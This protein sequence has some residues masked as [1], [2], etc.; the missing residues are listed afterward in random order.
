[1]YSLKSTA[2][3]KSDLDS[4]I[5]KSTAGVLIH[6]LRNDWIDNLYLLIGKAYFLRNDLDSA[7]LT[8]QFV[9]YTFS[10][11]EKDGYDKVIGSNQEEGNA[12]SISTKENRNLI[13]KML[14]RPPSRNESLI[15]QVKTYLAKNELPEAGGLIETLRHDP[16]F[17]SRLS[18]DLEELQ[19]LFFY[20]QEN[21]DS[22]AVHLEQALGNAE[23]NQE[24]ARWEYLIAQLYERA[25]H[26]DLAREFY[27]RS[28]RHT[29][30]PLMEVYGRLNSIRQ[31]RN[32]TKKDVDEAV[33]A[34]V[35]M[36]RKD[37]Y[38]LYRDIIFYTAA[39][40][41]LE[42][43]EPEAAKA[44]LLRSVAYASLQNPEQRTI[45]Y[46]KLGDIHYDQKFFSPAK[47]FYDS[48]D[49]QNMS[50]DAAKMFTAR[51]TAL[52][53]IFLQ[54]AIIERQDSLGKIAAM[55]EK[56]REVFVKQLVKKLRK[57]QG[58]RDDEDGKGVI[59]N[60]LNSIVAPD[61]FGSSKTS[62][63][64]YF[65]NPAA[66]AK[67]FSD[68]KAK[69]GSRP[70][71]DNWRRQS[72]IVQP[73]ALARNQMMG[74]DL[75]RSVDVSSSQEITFESLIEKLPLTPEKQK[76]AKDSVE[77]AWFNMAKMLMN[78]LEE[79]PSAIN[80]FEKLLEIF[81]S[82]TS[83]EEALFD[84]SYCYGKIG[85]TADANR[86]KQLL[87]SA[88]PNGKFAKLLTITNLSMSPDSIMK[89]KATRKY[90]SVYD[91]F[92]EGK[93]TEAIAAKKIADSTY[94][95]NFWTPQLLY[96]QSI[97]YI[98]ERDDSTAKDIL[99]KIL[100]RFPSSPMY[101]KSANLLSVL[102][103][104]KEI[105]DYLTK[106]EIRR[107][108]VDAPLVRAA[109][110]PVARKSETTGA[111]INAVQTAQPGIQP[112]RQDSVKV[113]PPIAVITPAPKSD[114][115]LKAIKPAAQKPDTIA[116]SV[117]LP[118]KIDTPLV[119]IAPKPDTVAKVTNFAKK[120][121]TS[122]VAI[123]PKPE[124]VAR[125]ITPEKKIDTS[126][127]SVLLKPDT[128]AKK[129]VPAVKIDSPFVSLL[130]KPETASKLPV[131]IVPPQSKDSAKIVK[132]PEISFSGF[133]SKPDMPH[134]VVLVFDRVDPVYVTEARNAFN[135][136][137]REKYLSKNI[138]AISVS[139]SDDVKFLV[140]KN[141]ENAN[142]ALLY[143]ENTSKFTKTDII[144]WLTPT[145]Y[146]FVL[147]TDE[148]LEK[149]KASKDLGNYRKFLTLAF[150]GKF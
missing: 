134:N 109:Q 43:N 84:L 97:Y 66:K 27:N 63:E 5:Y 6:D 20:N 44:L 75:L 37:K 140:L 81:P 71:A 56:E 32:G 29:L 83:R 16:Q 128:I 126:L 150:P 79:Y 42:R 86:V 53:Q 133:T 19:A 91:L 113:S 8:F 107:P 46:L 36:A 23:N 139:L 58:I 13:N 48:V 26:A 85:K 127:A 122:L 45:S 34:L 88:Y 49:I 116:K 74:N 9:N 146:S 41:E 141:F 70:N 52:D 68:F 15:W 82:T 145:K 54:S 30:D 12:F 93:F 98:K 111:K 65:A 73:S 17:P 125:A 10:P 100:Q 99:N 18:N 76:V 31:N 2:G 22:A 129:S 117:K 28:I 90:E 51:K 38:T 112:K 149:L 7:Y 25:G 96:I 120:I 106:L 92:I 60:Q 40:I 94:G 132:A 135:R 24:R 61:L 108:E 78:G 147:M 115:I 67:G 105:E 144:P 3:S 110:V 101:F 77:N 55:P 4:V 131:A 114:S 11:K 14:S 138:E 121:D 80:G 57:Q 123:A 50:P 1:N 142:A 33:E 148:N 102:G 130:P 87:A 39:V 62:A 104:R 119:A 47:R 72:A 64:W 143:I 103:R 89:A 95:E 136:F 59:A 137:N 21:Y 118:K 69:W 124:R 35:K